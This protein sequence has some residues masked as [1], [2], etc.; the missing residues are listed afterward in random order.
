MAA[1]PK[2]VTEAVR[3]D[4]RSGM[5]NDA[6]TEADARI[7]GYARIQMAVCADGGTSA[8]EAECIDLST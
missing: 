3:A 5:N 4:N 7:E 1:F 8:Y 2:D 6:A